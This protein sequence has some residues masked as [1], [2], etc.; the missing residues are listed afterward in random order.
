MTYVLGLTGSIGMGKSTTATM[1]RDLGIA[2]HDADAEVHRLYGAE[3]VA[4]VARLYP[5]VVVDGR[6]DRERLSRHV[7]GSPE[8][9]KQLEALIHPLVRASETAFLARARRDKAPLVVLDI[10]LLFE[11]GGEARCDGVLVVSAS[12]EV[13]KARVL[14]RPGMS[15]AKFDGILARQMP[16]AEKRR[17]ADFVVDTGQGIDVARA[18]VHAIVENLTNRPRNASAAAEDKDT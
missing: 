11:T 15:Q 13:Q 2:V 18:Q 14:A 5:D 6:I 12:A 8:R 7:V 10:P 9:L 1:F 4:P 16:D 3:A 17:R